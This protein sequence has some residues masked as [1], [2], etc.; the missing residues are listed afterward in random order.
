[1]KKWRNEERGARKPVILDTIFLGAIV[2]S[3]ANIDVFSVFLSLSHLSFCRQFSVQFV[4]IVPNF[5]EKIIIYNDF[6]QK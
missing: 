4:L 5:I 1:M 3:A 6:C 2:R